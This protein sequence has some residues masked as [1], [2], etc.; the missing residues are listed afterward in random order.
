MKKQQIA[1]IVKGV[2]ANFRTFGGGQVTESNP[3]S[4]ALKD[5]PPQFAAGVDVEEVVRFVV[6]KAKR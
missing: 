2:A 4:L 1:Q 5:S 3:I 6:S